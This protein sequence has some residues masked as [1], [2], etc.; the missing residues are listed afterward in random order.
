MTIDQRPTTNDQSGQTLLEILLAIGVAGLVLIG[1]TKATTMALRNAQFA[2][3]Q[4]LA[5]KY[6]QQTMEKIRAKRDQNSWNTFKV[7]CTP[8]GLPSLSGFNQSIVCECYFNNDY[9]D[10]CNLADVNKVKATVTV[11]WDSHQA[12]LVSFLTKWE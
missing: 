11:S 12:L 5:T 3:N 7:D 4:T 2:R 6:A 8:S 1:L 10:D 9:R